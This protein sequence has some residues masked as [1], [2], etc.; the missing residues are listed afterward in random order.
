VSCGNVAAHPASSLRFHPSSLTIKTGDTVTWTMMDARE[1][2]PLFFGAVDKA[3]PNPFADA[4]GGNT[5]ASPSGAVG[6]GPQFPGSSFSLTFT[7]PGTYN[8]ICTLHGDLGMRGTVVVEGAA[9]TRPAPRP[10]TLARTGS[11]SRTPVLLAVALLLLGSLALVGER[12]LRR[13]RG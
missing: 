2:H 12:R 11:T 5:I 3:P 9:I 13:V 1:V 4:S 8:Y 10:G 6:S 7:G